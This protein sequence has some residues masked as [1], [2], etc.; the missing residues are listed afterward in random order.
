M[1]TFHIEKFPYH[2]SKPK[3]VTLRKFCSH[4]NL[5]FFAIQG[6][7]CQININGRRTCLDPCQIISCPEPEKEQCVVGPDGRPT[8]Q[9]KPGH[10]RNRITGRCNWAG[11]G[12]KSD[13]ECGAG[14]RCADSAAHAGARS[15]QDACVGVSCGVGAECVVSRPHVA[16]CRCAEGFTGKPGERAGCSPV[17]RDECRSDAQCDESQVN[18]VELTVASTINL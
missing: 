14:E 15:C 7:V 3:F 1:K 4:I 11:L 8:C 16:S 9:C 2:F 5:H 13:E 17:D 6:L 18:I 10:Q 12:C